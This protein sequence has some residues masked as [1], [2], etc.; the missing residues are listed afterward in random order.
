MS[1]EPTDA[2]LR[3]KLAFAKLPMKGLLFWE[4][5]LSFKDIEYKKIIEEKFVNIVHSFA[6][7][8]EE[9]KIYYQQILEDLKEVRQKISSNGTEPSEL[10]K[11]IINIRDAIIAKAAYEMAIHDMYNSGLKATEKK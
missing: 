3:L 11:E 10:R 2:V 1:T 6:Q 7:N 4:A 9:A 5:L 8:N